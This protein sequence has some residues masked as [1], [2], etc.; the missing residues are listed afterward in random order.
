MM[1]RYLHDTTTQVTERCSGHQDP[2]SDDRHKVVVYQEN[3][4]RK[5]EVE[6]WARIAKG[7]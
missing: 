6:K 2:M 3:E 4:R 7:N 1:D 5:A